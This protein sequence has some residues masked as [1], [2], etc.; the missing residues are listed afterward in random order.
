MYNKIKQAAPN[1]VI[2]QLRNELKRRVIKAKKTNN[3]ITEEEMV[4]G[5]TSDW[6]GS[7][8]IYSGMGITLDQL[9]EMGKE[10][11][12]ESEINEDTEELPLPVQRLVEKIG[13]NAPCPC[14][15]GKK[16]KKCCGK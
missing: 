9:V 16:Y 11:I 4:E 7:G 12:K 8:R 13:R 10:V 15:S 1:M 5:I 2:G 3:T 14:G 6:K